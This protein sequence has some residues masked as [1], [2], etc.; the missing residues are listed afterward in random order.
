MGATLMAIAKKLA[1]S[2]ASDKKT[3]KLV[4][5]VIAGLAVIAFLPLIFLLGMGNTLEQSGQNNVDYGAEYLQNMTP[6][7]KAVFDEINEAGRLIE[8]QLIEYDGKNQIVKAQLIY[9]SYFKTAPREKDFLEKYCSIFKDSRSDNQLIDML[10]NEFKLKIDYTEFMRTYT[11]IKNLSIDQYLFNDLNTKNNIDLA[12]WAVN[13][14]E[15][16]GVAPNTYG[17]ILD[18]DTFCR[19]S[20][21]NPDI[22]LSESLQNIRTCDNIG[23]LQSYLWFD[24]E[25]KTIASINFEEYNFD[26]TDMYNRS[27]SKGIISESG[28]PEAIGLGLKGQDGL[29]ICIGNNMV[30]YVKSLED[31]I[32]SENIQLGSHSEWTEWFEIPGVSYGEIT[33][34]D[35][36]DADSF[37][38]ESTE[39]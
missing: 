16:W 14:Y 9:L 17:N 32:I 20:S 36:S 22:N 2:L 1:L 10:N 39:E 27:E 33:E 24:P 38:T 13:A 3:W 12:T 30:I 11:L 19:I 18:N 31:G 37:D 23:L 21:E 8:E 35:S 7:Q 29:G 26:L 25:D 34:D 28:I 6:E 4:A 15:S 5:S